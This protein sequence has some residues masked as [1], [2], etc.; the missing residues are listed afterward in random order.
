MNWNHE[1]KTREKWD[2]RFMQMAHLAKMWSKDS[3][4]V[5]AT[6]VNSNRRVIGLGYNGFPKGI[7]DLGDR[8]EDKDLKRSLSVHAELNCIL[9]SIEK[10][11]ACTIYVT[12][13]PCS[14]C[15]KAIIQAGITRVASPKAEID[16]PTWGASQARAS[17][18][19]FEVGIEFTEQA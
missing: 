14:E 3:N 19:F 2:K 8:L 1:L 7:A 16:H 12:R 17:A 15:A 4:W 9:N 10:P 5:G 13:H 6:I 18:M 11:T